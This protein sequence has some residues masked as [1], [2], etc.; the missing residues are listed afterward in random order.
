MTTKPIPSRTPQGANI[1]RPPKIYAVFASP[2]FCFRSPSAAQDGSWRAQESAN[3]S[4]RGLRGRSK[5]PAKVAPEAGY[6]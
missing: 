3:R 4:P 1:K 5:A 2:L 6:P